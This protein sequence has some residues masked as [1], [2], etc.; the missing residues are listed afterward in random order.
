MKS[1]KL[2]AGLIIIMI[3]LF[4]AYLGYQNM[5]PDKI[6]QGVNMLNDLS[7]SLGG[8]AISVKYEKDKTGAV[9]TLIGG[10]ALAVL[11][12]WFILKSRK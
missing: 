7:T 1:E 6:E 5:L 2:I 10:G 8:E 12:I 11:G 4:I 3:G 9:L